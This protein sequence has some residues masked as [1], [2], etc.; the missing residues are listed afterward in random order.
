MHDTRARQCYI[1]PMN[2]RIRSLTAA[3][4]ARLPEPDQDD[5]ANLMEEF[6]A[7]RSDPVAFTPEEWAHLRVVDAEPFVPADPGD[8]AALFA[9]RV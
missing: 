8:V 4:E 1:Q 9:R 5:L 6:V 2:A 3:A 7:G